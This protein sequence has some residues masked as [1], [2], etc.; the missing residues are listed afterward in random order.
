[1]GDIYAKLALFLQKKP[2]F[3]ELCTV[4]YY[5]LLIV[6]GVHGVVTDMPG[7]AKSQRIV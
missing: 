1:M 7:E 4:S 6:V 5:L 2:R 3:A